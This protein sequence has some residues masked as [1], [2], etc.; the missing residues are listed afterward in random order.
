MCN[1]FKLTEASLKKL[2]DRSPEKI[3]Q[4]FFNMSEQETMDTDYQHPPFMSREGVKKD[5]QKSIEKE[6]MD[7]PAC[8]L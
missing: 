1:N 7:E 3:K 5:I 2:L 4:D 8:T 6:E